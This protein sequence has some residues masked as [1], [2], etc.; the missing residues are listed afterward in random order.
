MNQ[1]NGILILDL[2][3]PGLAQ[4][5]QLG[6][7]FVAQLNLMEL[8]HLEEGVDLNEPL[9]VGIQREEQP[10]KFGFGA[11]GLLNE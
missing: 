10:F 3:A 6:H 2:V 4:P 11:V 1:S 9:L 8:Q 7:V 5:T